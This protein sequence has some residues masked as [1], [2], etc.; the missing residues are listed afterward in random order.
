MT[1][2]DAGAGARDPTK[3]TAP[4]KKALTVKQTLAAAKPKPQDPEQAVS[5]LGLEKIW[6]RVVGEEQGIYVPPLTHRQYGQLKRVLAA[7]PEGQAGLVMDCCL[8]N[9]ISFVHTAVSVEAAWNLPKQ[10]SIAFLTQFVGVAVNFWMA[11]Q[12]PKAVLHPISGHLS[13]PKV[14]PAPPKPAEPEEKKPTYDEMM[15]IFGLK[16]L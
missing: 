11:K 10:P 16:K 3:T 1:E 4:A 12:K 14:P 7:S 9:W 15:E 6:R 13:A 2:E 5:V 8:H